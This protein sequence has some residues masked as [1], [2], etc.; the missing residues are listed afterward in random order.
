MFFEKHQDTNIT[1][2]NIKYFISIFWK[3]EIIQT[4]NSG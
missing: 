2:N 4:D 3:S 1:F